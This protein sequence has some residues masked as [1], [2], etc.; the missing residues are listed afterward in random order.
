MKSVF[1]QP[2]GDRAVMALVLL[3]TGV[4][5][6]AFQDSLMKLMSEYRKNNQYVAW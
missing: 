4:C 3:L 6:I 2:S 1:Q 5:A